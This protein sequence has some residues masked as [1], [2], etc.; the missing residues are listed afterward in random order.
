[1]E[2]WLRENA[3]Y[4]PCLV[5]IEGEKYLSPEKVVHHKNEIKDDNRI[6]NLEVLTSEAHMSLHNKIRSHQH[7][8]NP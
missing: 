3:P 5:E 2:N 8:V 7:A 1:M 4:S 6:E